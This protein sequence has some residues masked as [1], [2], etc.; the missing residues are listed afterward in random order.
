MEKWVEEM[1]ILIVDGNKKIKIQTFN[2]DDA[3]DFF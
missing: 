1:E 3:K 2:A